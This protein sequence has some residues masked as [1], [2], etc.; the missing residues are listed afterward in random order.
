MAESDIKRGI[1]KYSGIFIVLVA[2]MLTA[3]S[4]SSLGL[5]WAV[6]IPVILGISC[7]MGY[8]VSWKLMHLPSKKKVILLVLVLA[9]TFFLSLIFLIY[10]A[11]FSVPE[12]LKFVS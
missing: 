4:V 10:A 5:G 7:V 11:H 3:V 8:F 9:V 12:G 2:L 6:R 1:Q